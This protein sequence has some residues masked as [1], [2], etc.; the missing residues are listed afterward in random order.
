VPCVYWLV[1]CAD[2]AL[3]AGIATL[4]EARAIVDTL[5]ANCQRAIW[6]LPRPRLRRLNAS[7]HI[8]GIRVS[9]PAGRFSA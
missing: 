1:G 5:P 6:Q 3:F 4:D 9:D 7:V 8:A 2:P